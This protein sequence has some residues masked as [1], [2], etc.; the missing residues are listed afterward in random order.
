MPFSLY[1]ILNA[2]PNVVALFWFSYLKNKYI[3]ASLMTN[4]KWHS[5]L[6]FLCFILSWFDAIAQILTVLV[7][8]V[9]VL[10]NVCSNNQK[11]DPPHQINPGRDI[12]DQIPLMVMVLVGG[13]KQN[14]HQI[15]GNDSLCEGQNVGY[16]KNGTCRVGRILRHR[17]PFATC[18]WSNVC[19]YNRYCAKT[20][21]CNLY[22]IHLNISFH[23]QNH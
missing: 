6:V 11:S 14:A 19:Y 22:K 15:W 3:F 7:N 20:M 13:I 5:N 2:F 18:E 12:K 23:F 16:A 21:K 1:H 8:L 4:F 10:L 9:P 17:C